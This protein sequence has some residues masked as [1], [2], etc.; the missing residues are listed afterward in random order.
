MKTVFA[1]LAAATLLSA[2]AASQPTTCQSGN[3]IGLAAADLITKCGK[4]DSVK[5]KTMTLPGHGTPTNFEF[6]LY[7]DLDLNVHIRSGKVG[8]VQHAGQEFR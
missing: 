8:Y 2:S 7:N 4:P 6:W 3:L 5:L 1:T